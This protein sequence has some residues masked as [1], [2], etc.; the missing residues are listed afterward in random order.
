MCDS[1]HVTLTGAGNISKGPKICR[2]DP[3]DVQDRQSLNELRQ[4]LEDQ[5]ATLNPN[6]DDAHNKL[7][8]AKMTIQA[9]EISKRLHN[10]ERTNLKL[11]DEV[12]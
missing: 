3:Q 2:H 11:L 7:E 5:L 6:I 12:P 8:F 10:A 4:Y 9:I 1:V